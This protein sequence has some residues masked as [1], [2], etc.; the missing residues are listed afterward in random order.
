MSRVLLVDD[1][2]IVRSGIR[3]LLVLSFASDQ[4]PVRL[5]L[6]DSRGK[7]VETD[8]IGDQKERCGG[9]DSKL[10]FGWL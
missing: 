2:A 7:A 4:L 8:D 5:L 9:D 1:H 3:R 10:L 6:V